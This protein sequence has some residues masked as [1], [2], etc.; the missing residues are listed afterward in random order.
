MSIVHVQQYQLDKYWPHVEKYIK[1]ALDTGYGEMNEHHA[2]LFISKGMSE[3]FAIEEDEK[4]TGAI[5]VEF[6]NYPNYRSANVISL[7]GKGVVKHWDEFKN[8]MRFGGASY[9]EGHCHKSMSRLMKSALGLEETYSIMR[10][11]L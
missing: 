2:R 9:V 1:D 4:I 11:K 3:L 8:W 10:G 7:G 6:I 5:L